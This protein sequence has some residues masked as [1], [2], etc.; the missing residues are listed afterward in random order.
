MKGSKMDT[1]RSPVAV[2]ALDRLAPVIGISAHT[3]PVHVA[4]FDITATFASSQFVDG[5]ATAGGQPVL[6]PPLPDIDQVMDRLD[7]LLLLPGPDVD[8]AL[9]AASPHPLSRGINP[10][11]DEAELSLL[12]AAL[13]AD[14][15]VLGIC[16]GAQLLNILRGGTLHQHL[17]DI[18]GHDRHLPAVDGYG[19]EPVRVAPSSCLARV[20]GTDQLIV[21][22]HHHQGIDRLGLGIEATAWSVADDIVEAIE[23]AGQEFAVGVQWHAERGGAGPDLFQ[24]FVAACSR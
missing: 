24:E 21:P 6:L 1:L 15:P 5:V 3:G 8:P 20:A 12:A 9:Y 10:A 14:I 22:C 16:R 13:E 4:V 7:G 17:P 23:V 18:L 11:R 2:R 19:A